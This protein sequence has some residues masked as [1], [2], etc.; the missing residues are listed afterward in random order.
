MVQIGIKL[1][2]VAVD[3]WNQESRAQAEAVH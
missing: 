1:S 3:T 2:V